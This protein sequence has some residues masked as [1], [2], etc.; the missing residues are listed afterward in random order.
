MA[1]A[2]AYFPTLADAQAS[3]N[4]LGSSNYTV[5]SKGG[6]SSW[7]IAPISTGSSP[8]NAIYPVG[9]ILNGDGIYRLYPASPC[10]LQGSSVLCNIDNIETNLLVENLKP[11]TLVKTSHSGFKKVVLVAKGSI[12]NP[13]GKERIQNRLYKCSPSVYPELKEDLFITGDHSIIV[14]NITEKQR[15]TMT[16][17]LGKIYVTERQY[18][19]IA[20]ADERAEPWDS[21]GTYDIWHFALENEDPKMNYGVYA[22]GGLLVETCSIN[23][24]K[25]KSNMSLQE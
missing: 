12:Q 25:N 24:L 10:F 7:R 5:E 17:H 11:G 4:G 14:P 20:F 9:A 13:A 2:V 3:T 16:A 22:N 1:P 15:E 8:Q 18:R 6:Y 23:T 19:L 21:E